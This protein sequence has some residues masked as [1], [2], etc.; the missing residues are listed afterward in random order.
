MCINNVDGNFM[1]FLRV[2][3][4]RFFTV[5]YAGF[6]RYFFGFITVFLGHF[7]RDYL[8]YYDLQIILIC[9]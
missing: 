6:S 1:L 7:Q 9:N 8:K 2:K 3:R 4:P 5:I